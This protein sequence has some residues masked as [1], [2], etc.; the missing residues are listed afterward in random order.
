[1]TD[2]QLLLSHAR[3]LKEK[4]AESSVVTAT[5]FL[6][7][8]ERALLCS[9]E[10]EQSEYVGTY[11]FGGYADAERTAA[12]FI[13]KF[14]EAQSAEDFFGEYPDEN[15]FCLIKIEKD[16]FS[17]LTHRD[18]LG[19]LMG[20]GLRRE[21]LGDIIVTDGGCYVPCIKS[22]AQFILKN[23]SSVGRGAV[24]AFEAS[25]GEIAEREERSQTVTACVASLRL[26]N[27]VS[28][29]FSV[30]RAAA[31]QFIEKGVVFVDSQVK[32]KPDYK[33]CEGAKIVLR[34]KGK[35]VFEETAGESKKG[36]LHIKIKGSVPIKG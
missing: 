23:L 28:A 6:T 14:Y 7:E 22:V 10:K 32:T 18:Y 29:C 36:R 34:G 13:P 3:D 16:R 35:A 25:F 19:S 2:E 26:D 33:V 1:M 20:L 11:Y 30:S 15:P 17:S 31:A 21:A 8:S 4:S 5:A 12:V 24:K 27:V 9:L